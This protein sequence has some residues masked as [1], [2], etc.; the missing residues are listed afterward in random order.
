MGYYRPRRTRSGWSARGAV[1]WSIVRSMQFY[2]LVGTVLAAAGRWRVLPMPRGVLQPV[3]CADA[4]KVIADVA[5]GAA[6]KRCF[7]VAGPEVRELRDLA[8]TWR[9]VTGHR[10]VLIPMAVPG[11]VG[12]A[13]RSGALTAPQP[14]ARGTTGFADWLR[15]VPG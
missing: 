9:E 1:P 10:A 4:A 2:E 8:R 6:L 7:T 11:T 5:E 3:A 15:S 14:D 13:L 12:R